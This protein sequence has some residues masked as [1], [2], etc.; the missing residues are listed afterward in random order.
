M[1]KR[2]RRAFTKEFKAEAVRIVQASGR[3]VG[4]V[5][6]ELDLTE[7]A[8]REW[9][10]QAEIDAGRG[11]PG[12]LT[13]DERAEL[14]QLRREVRTLRMERDI[15][16][17][18]D[19]LLRQGERVRVAFIAAEKAAFPV[20]VLCRILAVS[21]A[22]FYAA[23]ARPV[24]G[25]ARRDAQLAVE[26]A[27][28]HGES[29]QR[30]GSPRVHAELRARGRGVSRKRGARLMRHQG[31]AARRRRRYRVT[32]DSRHP[33]PV[34]ANVLARQ[35]TAPAPDAVWVTD[36]TYI[37][38]R[39]GRLYLAVILDLCSRGI[40]GWAMSERITRQ[41]TLDALQHAL[42]AADRPRDCC[43]TPTGG[44]R[45]PAATTRQPSSAVRSSAA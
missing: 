14:A 5:A 2:K 4:A 15:L 21:R 39:E 32:T 13:T 26:I 25:R 12:V 40:V 24:A 11:Q 9:V 31:L 8:L 33:F 7:P 41:L 10:R 29:R 19:G 28:I 18:S 42:G 6:R 30:Y 16:K 38:T 23:Q 1:A 36:I 22:G 44:A 34:A 20:T 17:K 37:P 3:T 35:F 27:A 45:T 43:I